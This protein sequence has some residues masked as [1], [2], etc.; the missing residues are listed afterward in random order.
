MQNNKIFVF[1][2]AGELLP[3]FPIFGISQADITQDNGKNII[4]FL[5]EKNT[6]FVYEF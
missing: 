5:K 2:S 4:A 1:S 3:S 6:L